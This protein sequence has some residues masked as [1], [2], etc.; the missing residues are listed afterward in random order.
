MTFVGWR[1]RFVPAPTSENV[2]NGILWSLL[3]FNKSKPGMISNEQA[4]ITIF[5]VKFK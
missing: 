1:L 2:P 5:F 3:N 4:G